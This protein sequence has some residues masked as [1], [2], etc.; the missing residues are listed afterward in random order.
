MALAGS[1]AVLTLMAIHYPL[2]TTWPI[3]GDAAAIIR[4]AKQIS[5]PS[6]LQSR[7]P[8][9]LLEFNLTRV[10]PVSWP[11]RYVWFMAAGQI[12]TGLALGWWLWRVAGGLAAA[13]GIFAWSLTT[14]TINNH[15][16][17]GTI[18]QLWS[19]PWLLLFFECLQSGRQRAAAGA[20]IL[21]A[22]TH[23][24]TGLLLLASL[25]LASPFLIAERKWWLA[26]ITALGIVGIGIMAMWQPFFFVALLVDTR[27][28]SFSEIIRSFFGPWLLI[29]PLG[30]MIWL[31]SLRKNWV[32]AAVMLAWLIITLLA[33]VSDR[34]GLPFAPARWQ[35][36]IIL[37][38]CAAGGLAWPQ[39]MKVFPWRG[40]AVAF[41]IAFFTTMAMAAWQE[42]ARVYAYYESPSRYARLH[43]LEL[44]AIEWM[45]DHLPAGS[46][47]AS[48][49]AN[50]HT[51]WIPI[52]TPHRWHGF[53]PQ[54]MGRPIDN[55][56]YTHFIS[57]TKREKISGPYPFDPAQQPIAFQNEAAVLFQLQPVPTP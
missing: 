50:R 43:P 45:R 10:L 33:V 11:E 5:W 20:L 30:L 2:A 7:Y 49:Q 18:A 51:E 14:T 29:A 16:E 34:L 57:Y 31:R 26:T 24:V 4:D 54:E 13:V 27:S 39:L 42:H 6:L 15:F 21:S 52:L 12:A 17:D 19:L 38:L 56:A 48:S 37:A 47:I 46:F 8:L 3:G 53:S 41:S 23:P 9:F 55:D 25:A 28:F 1:F 36:Y 32:N 40:L 22:G 44:E 35:T